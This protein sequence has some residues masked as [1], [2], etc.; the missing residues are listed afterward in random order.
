MISVIIIE[1]MLKRLDRLNEPCDD[2]GFNCHLIVILMNE[3]DSTAMSDQSQFDIMADE[4]AEILLFD[5]A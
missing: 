2:V 5:L 3:G 1:I 4:P